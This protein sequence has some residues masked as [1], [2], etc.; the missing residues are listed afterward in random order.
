MR[1]KSQRERERERERERKEGGRG[2]GTHQ[3]FDKE[4]RV[5]AIRE[6]EVALDEAL[7]GLP[8]PLEA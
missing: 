3:L 6:E 8:P 5:L 1:G 7:E 2:Q 4:S